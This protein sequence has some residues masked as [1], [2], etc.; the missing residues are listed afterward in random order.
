MYT[1]ATLSKAQ[2]HANWQ[3]YGL[4]AVPSL[5]KDP[6]QF[7]MNSLLEHG[8][9]VP[10][11]LGPTRLLLVHHPDHAQYV[12]QDNWRNYGKGSMWVAIRKLV[13]NG[14]LASEGD[15][16]LR[17]RRLMQ[18]AFHRQRLSELTTTITATISEMMTEWRTA[19]QQQTPIE[20]AH[21]MADL[22]MRIIV[23]T[24]F[25]TGIS[26]AETQ[27][28]VT[29][30]ADA[31]RLMNVRM[32]TFFLPDFVPL[33]GDAAFRSTIQHIDRVVYR[34]IAEGRQTPNTHTLLHMLLEMQDEVSGQKMTDQQ[35]RDEVF[36]IFMAGHETSATV[37]A[38]VLHLI[39]QH[40]D[41]ERRLQREVDEVLAG[42]VP[43]FDDLPRLTYTRMVIEEAVRMYPPAWLIPR[44]AE[45]DDT[46]GGRTVKAGTTIL[47][48]PYV[49]HR[50]PQFWEDAE[51]FDP[52]RFAN[53]REVPRHAY[54]AFGEGPRLCIGNSFAIME[55]QLM[56]AMI[57][58]SYRLRLQ[59]GIDIRP[60]TMPVLRPDH[61]LLM[62][63]VA[64]AGEQ[65]QY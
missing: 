4:T 45:A 52:E 13:G 44:T 24:M 11:T 57:A 54:I 6:L 38:W 47:I 21:A 55:M 41:V 40:P 39:W 29:V 50:H 35:V 9:L 43:A 3:G 33:P 26:N 58:Q 36:T 25:G 18:P 10:I 63:P 15:Y 7:F 32:W 34:F 1:I 22:T 16:W 53:G 12:L 51:R 59:P 37:M 28:L 65:T 19:E 62:M 42:R 49:V 2:Q 23:R 27:E 14:L 56:L 8:D 5:A 61:D 30:F 17:Q 20:M 31:L 60:T 64:R 46:I 48:S